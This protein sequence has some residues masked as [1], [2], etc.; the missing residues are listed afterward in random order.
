MTRSSEFSR[1][2]IREADVSQHETE[3]TLDMMEGGHGNAGGGP[4]GGGP[5]SGG[6]SSGLTAD[7]QV[8]VDNSIAASHAAAMK[9]MTNNVYLRE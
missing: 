8:V 9:A 5:S 7:E 2:L 4:P 6:P 3:Q 1:R